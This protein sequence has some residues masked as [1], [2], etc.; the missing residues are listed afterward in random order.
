MSPQLKEFTE[1]LRTLAEKSGDIIKPYF[2]K[3]NLEVELKTDLT[4]VT[5]ADREAEAV[6]VT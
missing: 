5:R 4:P 3:T 1:F 6:M 2:A